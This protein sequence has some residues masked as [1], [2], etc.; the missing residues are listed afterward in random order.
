M[1]QLVLHVERAYKLREIQ[2]PLQLIWNQ[3]T[4]NLRVISLDII[5]SVVASVC[6]FEFEAAE[7]SALTR[8]R[9]LMHAIS[10]TFSQGK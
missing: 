3:E 7:S 5:G 2:R 1:H 9:G 4:L 8:C 6:F 10:R